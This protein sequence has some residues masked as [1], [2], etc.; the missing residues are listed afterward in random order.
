MRFITA[1][2]IVAIST[3]SVFAY[4]NGAPN[5]YAGNPPQNRN[6]TQCHDDYPVNSGDGSVAITGLPAGG[7]V[8]GYTYD[9]GVTVTDPGQ[10]RWG[11]ELAVLYVSGT[12]YLQAGT[13]I[14]TQ[15]TTTVISSSASRDYLKQIVSGTFPGTPG[16]TSWQFQWTAPDITVDSLTFYVA[17]NAA[18][19]S[20]TFDGDYIYTVT[21]GLT[22]STNAAPVVSDIPNQT[23]AYGETFTTIDLDD[24]VADPDTPDDQISWVATG[25]NN[26]IVDIST[27][28]IATLTY[29]GWWGFETI[30]FTATDPTSLSDSD[31]AVFTVGNP[32]P[33]VVSDIPN[34]TIEQGQSFAQIMLDDYVDDPD[35]PDSLITWT[36]SLTNNLTIEI[37]DRIATIT[38]NAAWFGMEGVNF[39]ATDPEDNTDNDVASFTVTEVGVHNPNSGSIPSEFSLHQNYPNP[40]NAVTT[41]SFALPITSEIRLDIYDNSGRLMANLCQG[42][43]NAGYY[44]IDVDMNNFASGVY[45]LSLQAGDFSGVRK[46]VLLK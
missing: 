4:S 5:A 14:C 21:Y 42:S 13:L 36:T 18:N 28:R 27:D 15:Q 46:L 22:P 17:G 35:T 19:N 8:P 30:T 34:Q 44:D 6:C 41:V 3:F 2:L 26:I 45:L 40:F 9:L 29:T 11:F 39:F 7:F 32:Q 33:P 16:P 38:Y 25:Y 1:L 23:I 10:Q 43:Y 24:Y 31:D 37:I 12:S 20:S